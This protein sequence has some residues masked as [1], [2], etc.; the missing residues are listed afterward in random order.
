MKFL[1]PKIDTKWKYALLLLT[2]IGSATA[3][4]KIRPFKTKKLAKIFK[5]IGFSLTNEPYV[6]SAEVALLSKLP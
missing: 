1:M 3:Q 2:E 6:P 5:K 4:L